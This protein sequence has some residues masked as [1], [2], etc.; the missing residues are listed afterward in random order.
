[1]NVTL[2]QNYFMVENPLWIAKK[3]D[4]GIIIPEAARAKKSE[5]EVMKDFEK[6]LKFKV[7]KVG[8]GCTKIKEGSEVFVSPNVS[9]NP[10]N[11]KI[12]LDGKGYFIFRESDVIMT[13]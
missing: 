5:E 11:I 8:E 13:Y 2:M 12:E 3:T 10:N 6:L 4:A 9:C 7:I 1:M